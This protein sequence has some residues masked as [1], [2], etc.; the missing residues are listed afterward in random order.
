MLPVER[1]SIAVT[2]NLRCNNFAQRWLPRNPAPPVTTAR[3]PLPIRASQSM[4]SIPDTPCRSPQR[5]FQSKMRAEPPMRPE[6]GPTISFKVPKRQCIRAFT[7]SGPAPFN[8]VNRPSQPGNQLPAAR[9][10][11]KFFAIA[12]AGAP[13]QGQAGGATDEAAG[14]CPVIASNAGHGTS[15]P[16]RRPFSVSFNLCGPA[17]ACRAGSRFRFRVA[18]AVELR[19]VVLLTPRTARVMYPG[20]A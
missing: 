14:S 11:R 18:A 19:H 4:A 7:R 2:S 3:F 12:A 1:L 16:C 17:P 6:A 13:S 15:M 5:A 10:I 8:K 20:N 9:S